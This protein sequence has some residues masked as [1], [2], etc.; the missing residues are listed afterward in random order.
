M[1]TQLEQLERPLALGYNEAEYAAALADVYLDDQAQLPKAEYLRRRGRLLQELAVLAEAPPLDTRPS[2]PADLPAAEEFAATVAVGLDLLDEAQ[3]R[4]V[5]QR[6]RLQVDVY[7]EEPR[8][9]LRGLFPTTI[10]AVLS[11]P[12]TS[13]PQY[14]GVPFVLT[15]P[16]RVPA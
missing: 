8:L 12:S 4:A 5:L 10:P 9:E 16:L 7:P 6:L 11:P 3:R 13:T 15:I 1:E 2:T 14:G